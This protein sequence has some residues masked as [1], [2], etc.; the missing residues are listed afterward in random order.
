MTRTISSAWQAAEREQP[1]AQRR[2][3]VADW[4]TEWDVWSRAVLAA[5]LAAEAAEI[6]AKKARKAA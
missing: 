1:T 3:D 6:E 4:M 5:L 2:T